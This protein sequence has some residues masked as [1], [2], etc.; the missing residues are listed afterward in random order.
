MT[1]KLVVPLLCLVAVACATRRVTV[2]PQ[3]EPN[4]QALAAVRAIYL[5]D[6]G[7]G[8]GANLVRERVRFRLLQATRF[9]AVES[10]GQADAVLTGEAGVERRITEGMTY[11][12]D[13]SL[14]RL[15]D[16]KT[17]ETIWI[18]EYRDEHRLIRSEDMNIGGASTRAANQ[19]VDELL[20]AAAPH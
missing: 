11:Y 10:A 19:I 16:A 2:N 12:L 9:T 18:H 7:S 1:R 3:P 6:F 17:Q 20:K 14:L 8:E 4:R 5:G 13:R 15:I